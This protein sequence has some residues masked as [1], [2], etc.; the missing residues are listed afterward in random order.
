MDTERERTVKGWYSRGWRTYRRHTKP[1]LL[2]SALL[3]GLSLLFTLMNT[4]AKGY[5]V[6]M[7]SQ[8]FILPVFS[9]GWLFLCLK[10]V[11][12]EEVRVTHIF[13]AFSMYGRAW[14]TY[15]LYL[16]IVVGGVFLLV[17][18]GI[19]WAVKYGMSLFAVTDRSLVARNAYRYSSTITKGYRWKLFV[20]LVAASALNA[21]SVP[22]SMGLEKIGEGGAAPLLLFGAVPLLV[23]MF[24]VTPWIGPSFAS[25]YESLCAVQEE[26]GRITDKT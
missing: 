22:F 20:A 3:F 5:W 4:L 11:R 19:F 2:S 12:N 8:I 10:G 18:P 6:I 15:I 1:L 26:G 23:C 9:I 16:L 25:A 17:V 21:L 24:V 13:T 14:V 7:I